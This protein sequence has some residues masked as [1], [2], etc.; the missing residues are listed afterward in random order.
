MPDRLNARL[1]DLHHQLDGVDVSLAELLTAR[2][3]HERLVSGAAE[4]AA[5]AAGTVRRWTSRTMAAL[6]VVALLL[7]PATAYGAIVWHQL[8]L[9]NCPTAAAPELR[10][11]WYCG[12]F[13]NTHHQHGGD[14]PR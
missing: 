12:M 1:G 14:D 7:M 13:P 3:L 9:T 4:Q 11:A 2:D 5:D 10:G 8:V 6:A